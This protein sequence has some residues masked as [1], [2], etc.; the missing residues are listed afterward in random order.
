MTPRLEAS[1]RQHFHE[2]ADGTVLEGQIDRVGAGVHARHQAPGWLARFRSPVPAVKGD[3]RRGSALTGRSLPIGWLPQAAG[4]VV[5][6]TALGWAVF[7]MVGGSS[8]PPPPTPTPAAVS[9]G[10]SV[11]PSPADPCLARPDGGVSVGCIEVAQGWTFS[12][13]DH[14]AR[15]GPDNDAF[16]NVVEG[17]LYLS[18]PPTWRGPSLALALSPSGGRTGCLRA[19]E[20][21]EIEQPGIELRSLTRDSVICALAGD[22][23]LFELHIVLI[24]SPAAPATATRAAE[25]SWIDWG[26]GR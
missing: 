18:R 5:A 21:S 11:A 4:L 16:L 14:A 22:G 2:M 12:L 24:R 15:I 17:E 6:A 9:A 3:A 23:R 19:L 13:G 7:A 26:P 8:P 25:F 10:P 1:L 20:V